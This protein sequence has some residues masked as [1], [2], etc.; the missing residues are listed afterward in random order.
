[1]E[2]HSSKNKDQDNTP[3]KRV[4][5]IREE[6]AT[7]IQNNPYEL[8]HTIG[9]LKRG[10]GAYVYVEFERVQPEVLPF[11][12]IDEMEAGKIYASL[13]EEENTEEEKNIVYYIKKPDNKIITEKCW[14]NPYKKEFEEYEVDILEDAYNKNLIDPF[15]QLR[16]KG[17]PQK[18]I[19]Y[20]EKYTHQNGFLNVSRTITIEYFAGKLRVISPDDFRCD[21]IINPD[22]KSL[23]FIETFNINRY[24]RLDLDFPESETFYKSGRKGY[25][26]AY[27]ETI[28]TISFDKNENVVNHKFL[29]DRVILLS[30]QANH[31][32]NR[33]KERLA[34]YINF[35]DDETI[36]QERIGATPEEIKIEFAQHRQYVKE[37][38]IE[39]L[40]KSF[41]EIVSLDE[42]L[43]ELIEDKGNFREEQKPE[44]QKP[45]EEKPVEMKFTRKNIKKELPVPKPSLMNRLTR[46][47][48]KHPWLTALIVFAITTVIVSAIAAGIILSG[49]GATAGL[50]LVPAAIKF[51]AGSAVT[52]FTAKI[53]GIFAT[54]LFFGLCAAIGTITGIKLGRWASRGNIEKL[55][56]DDDL[57]T[58]LPDDN[59]K[60]TQVEIGAK[61]DSDLMDDSA[62]SAEEFS[63]EQT[64]KNH[65]TLFTH[66]PEDADIEEVKDLTSG[67][68][69]IELQVLFGSP[70]I[71]EV[72]EKFN[73]IDETVIQNFSKLFSENKSE[74]EIGKFL[75][76]NPKLRNALVEHFSSQQKELLSEVKGQTKI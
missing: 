11:Q 26:L 25:P 51:V 50:I 4:P 64:L 10:T 66:N 46:W 58:N 53:L 32:F 71:Q 76:Q 19:E 60:E 34:P 54:G 59:K 43:V 21:I 55:P 45:E 65:N 47:I 67:N 7:K 27:C 30:K 57:I 31:L 40:K 36:L 9:D 2:S 37:G 17:L 22:K 23:T 52:A 75:L 70:Q 62:T 48:S 33:N 15:I 61:L 35:D 14:K 38:N 18:I 6:Y 42:E 28:S 12:N 1:M 73:T 8:K 68:K 44:E 16:N 69:L 63:A 41:E 20:L 56:T 49:G 74:N 39:A 24:K 13:T 72:K 5:G 29:H 3:P